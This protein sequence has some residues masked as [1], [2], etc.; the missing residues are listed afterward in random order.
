VIVTLIKLSIL[1]L[2]LVLFPSVKFKRVV[3]GVIATQVILCCSFVIGILVQCHPLPYYWDKSIGGTC[4]PDSV[5]F[6][7]TAV[8]NMV[9]DLLVIFLP[10][11]VIWR[12]QMDKRRK[13]AIS[14]VFGLGAM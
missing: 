7:L 1:N 6:I 11:R 12:L 9:M 10:V 8:V 3:H 4:V 14:I 2:Y 5:G 13:I